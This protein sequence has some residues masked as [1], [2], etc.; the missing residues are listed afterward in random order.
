MASSFGYLS[1][2]VDVS[3]VSFDAISK[4]MQVLLLRNIATG[5]WVFSKGAMQ[6]VKGCVLASPSLPDDRG[7]TDQDYVHHWIRDAAICIPEALD[8]PVFTARTICEDYTMFSALCQENAE[9]ASR[10]ALACFH[11][12]GTVRDNWTSQTDG[13]AHRILS[14]LAIEDRLSLQ[15]L[16]TARSIIEKDTRYLLSAYKEQTHNLWEETA[17]FS[18]YARSVQRKAFLS[19]ISRADEHGLSPYINDMWAAAEWL[20]SQMATH[21]G[22][23]EGQPYYASI[24]GPNGRPVEGRGATLNVDVVMSA[25]YGS[26]NCAD[27][28]LLSTAALVREAFT[29]GDRRYRINDADRALPR[30]RGPMIG[31]YPEDTY[32]GNL[33]D[34]GPDAGHPWALTT[35]NF[36]EL[37]FMLAAKIKSSPG[38]VLVNATTQK[39]FA[40]VGVSDPADPD[41][42]AKL[43]DAGDRMLEAVIYHSDRL[44]LSEQFDR[45]NGYECSVS[46]LSW[47]YATFRSA[48]R[49]REAAVGDFPSRHG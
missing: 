12:D 6:S 10:F 43:I 30:S 19:L 29:Q 20:G 4:Y 16:A 13:P 21:Q 15:A 42:A 23:Y 26:T 3:S 38:A 39:F 34:H 31:R 41:I 27:P 36:A 47:S 48:V 49:A 9:R 25:V 2:S 1:T 45:D 14:L 35:C 17:G 40:Q 37:Y 46:D 5:T 24:T 33:S 32:D 28:V 18:F 7:Q 11:I 44:Q 22:T 8:N